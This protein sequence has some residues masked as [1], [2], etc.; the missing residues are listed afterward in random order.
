MHTVTVCTRGG[1]FKLQTV[2]PP[3]RFTCV[4]LIPCP[5]LDFGCHAALETA[6]VLKHQGGGSDKKANVTYRLKLYLSRTKLGVVID[7]LD[8]ALSLAFCAAYIAETYYTQLPQA[9]VI[10]NAICTASF[11]LYFALGVVLAQER[12]HFLLSINSAL[13]LLTLLPFL[14]LVVGSGYRT[15]TVQLLRL[16]VVARISH[17]ESL[18]RLTRTD[19]NRQVFA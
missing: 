7:M 2:R 16:G 11:L 19:I 8:L 6:P 10:F 1:G 15:F 14:A 17:V 9:V 18:D 12:K 13:D 5:V 4:L 3:P